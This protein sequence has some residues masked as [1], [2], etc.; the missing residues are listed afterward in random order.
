MAFAKN[1]FAIKRYGKL[2]RIANWLQQLPN[3]VT[4][5]PFRLIQIGSAF[6][7]SRALYVG[8]KLELADEIGEMEKSTKILAQVLQLNEDHLYRLMRMLASMGIFI[9]TSPR[10]FKNSKLSSYLRKDNTKNVRSM[11]LMHNSPEM[12][13]P[14]FESLESSIRDGSIPFEKV[15]GIDLF[16]YMDQ[17]NEFD[18]L[19][20]QAMDSVENVAG[21]QF[22]EDFD[23]SKFK[24]IIDVGGSTGSKSLSIL[25][26]NP[27]LK[28]V[29]YDRP[30]TINGAKE[31]W[32]GK[33]DGSVLNRIEFIEGDI[34]E[35]IPQ[36][37][38]DR[39]V[40]FFMAVFHTFND[41]NCRHILNNLKVAIGDKSSCVV[42]AD[43]VS[44][45]AN[46]DPIVASMD[47]QMLMGTKGRERTLSEWEQLFD[48]T[49]FKIMSVMD[50]RSLVKY[51]VLHKQ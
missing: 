48:E 25:K 36:S 14:W 23:W 26:T 49:G 33:I 24:R 38:S 51:I 28:A 32:Q 4:P 10:V 15:N 20:S 2:M 29:V 19:F 34:L 9:E 12:T 3:K 43:A 21:V 40:Y 17:D 7:Q 41:E 47:M 44:S 1:K 39:D 45:E 11:I 31:K 8:T 22:L 42:I 50:I 30:Q 16:E 18:S 35:S 37:E 6:W 46:L 5:P 13:K 27:E